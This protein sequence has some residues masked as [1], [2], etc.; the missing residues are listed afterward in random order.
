MTARLIDDLPDGSAETLLY[1]DAPLGFLKEAR[2]DK[3]AV[4]RAAGRGLSAR[5]METF[6]NDIIEPGIRDFVEPYRARA[7]LILTMGENHAV[8][9]VT[10]PADQ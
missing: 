10:A 1:L 2:L 5:D 6:W 7:D 4:L 3:E 8:K 9:G